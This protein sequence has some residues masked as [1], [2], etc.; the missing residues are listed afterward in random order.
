MIV[1]QGE[2]S[3]WQGLRDGIRPKP[4]C[5]GSGRPPAGARS[6]TGISLRLPREGGAAP[7][8]TLSAHRS[9][10][11]LGCAVIALLAAVT[12]APHA[13]VAQQV[14]GVSPTGAEPQSGAGAT[15]TGGPSLACGQNA[16]A[17]GVASTAVGADGAVASGGFST[18]VGNQSTA[19]SSGS[20]AFGNQVLA[21][22]D[23]S[24][25]FGAGSAATAA[26]ATAV[27]SVER[28]QR[29]QQHGG[30]RAVRRHPNRRDRPRV[31]SPGNRLSTP[32]P[33]A[34]P[35]RRA[36]TTARLYGNAS[37]ASGSQS[38]ASGFS[39][40]GERDRQHG[41]RLGQHGER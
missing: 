32:R 22:G 26:N 12:L 19:S 28:E 36:A 31:S 40:H 34:S 41:H 3:P 15:A 8:S 30:W 13:A 4:M 16:T 9:G 21:T 1:D 10:L 35:A 27:G 39:K 33:P 25:A 2:G 23:G 29:P 20:S 18:V 7:G 14:C 11:M 24:S 6:R 38:T 17:S 37:I 5:A